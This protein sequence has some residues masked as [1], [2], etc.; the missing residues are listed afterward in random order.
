M[1]EYFIIANSFAAPFFSDSSNGYEKGET[2]KEALASFVKSYT[3][4]AGLYSAKVYE[5]ADAYH[6]GQEAVATYLSN[7]EIALKEATKDKGVYSY[8][9][10]AP[11]DFEV[12]HKN[13][14]IP[15]PKGGRIIE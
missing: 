4:P 6:K 1:N 11:G 9:G 13:Y 12:D 7:H 3:H 14:R 5:S 10:N 2:P 15:D 8:M